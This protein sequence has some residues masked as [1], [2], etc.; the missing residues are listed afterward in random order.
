M[1][2]KE[3][4]KFLASAKAKKLVGPDATLEAWDEYAW[5]KFGSLS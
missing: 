5:G 4:K 2:E 3:G 1:N